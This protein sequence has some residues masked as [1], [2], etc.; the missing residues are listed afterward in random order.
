[1]FLSTSIASA[2]AGSLEAQAP[3]PFPIIDTHIHLF[4]P[5]RPGGVPWPPPENTVLYRPALPER[6]RRIA[7]PLGIKGAIEVE[8]SPLVE[9]NQW[10]LDVEE[11]DTIMVGFIGNIEPGTADF[12]K[13]LDRY[14]KNKLYLGIRYGNLWGRNF[15]QA[16]AR[17]ECIGDLK[18][19]A[20]HGLTMD[21]ANPNPDLVAD[22]VKLTDAVPDL[23]LVIDHLPQ[24]TPPADAAANRVYENNLRELGKR[25]QVFVKVSEVLRKEKGKVRF[26]LPFY[27]RR[28]D[29]FFEIFGEDRLLYGSDWPNSDNWAEYPAV[30]KIVREYFAGKGPAA[31]EKYFWK[32]SVKAYRW[33]R[34][35]PGQPDP[36]KA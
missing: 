1:M 10:V 5:T 26:D 3:P 33:S 30:L 14:R 17:P 24:L 32:N 19:F 18:Y 11:R 23:R 16:I 36:A 4:D 9:D 2:A 22:Y 15:R 31:S 20:S 7:E 21:S 13:H 25:P 34:R 35:E 8:A 27:K 12:R 29:M 6:Y 28:L